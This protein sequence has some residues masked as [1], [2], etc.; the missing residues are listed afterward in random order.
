MVERMTAGVD[1]EPVTRQ[2]I[3]HVF[4][5]VAASTLAIG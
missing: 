1:K 3:L 5:A 2:Q 4:S